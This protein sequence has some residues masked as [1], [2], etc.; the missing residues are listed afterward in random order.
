MRAC[1]PVLP[2][3]S[4]CALDRNTSFSNL[5]GAGGH[6]R[7]RNLFLHSDGGSLLA[8]LFSTRFAP[9][10]STRTERASTH[11]SSL[12]IVTRVTLIK[13]NTFQRSLFYIQMKFQ[14]SSHFNNYIISN[15]SNNLR[16]TK[17]LL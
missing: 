12:D 11:L 1:S 5:G 16:Y 14:S 15:Q 10:S 13:D 17:L 2:P 6:Y 3:F 7:L 4:D 8:K 9:R